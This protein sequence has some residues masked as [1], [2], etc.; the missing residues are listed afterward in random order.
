MGV[1]PRYFMNIYTSFN[2]LPGEG[3]VNYWQKLLNRGVPNI[4]GS[5][6]F[7]PDLYP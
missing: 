1:G 2:I 4:I 6:F 5:E 3:Y 7:G